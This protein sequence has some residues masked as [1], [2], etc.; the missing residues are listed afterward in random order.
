LA[1]PHRDDGAVVAIQQTA[2]QYKPN[3]VTAELPNGVGAELVSGVQTYSNG[4]AG[5]QRW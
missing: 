2:A 5:D 4:R 3:A 1:E